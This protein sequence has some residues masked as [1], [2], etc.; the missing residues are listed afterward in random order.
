MAGGIS[1]SPARFRLPYGH[2]KRAT[3]PAEAVAGRR[4]MRQSCGGRRFAAR[5]HD[6]EPAAL[7]DL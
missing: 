1:N 2:T 5:P 7:E 3:A 6:V 4:L